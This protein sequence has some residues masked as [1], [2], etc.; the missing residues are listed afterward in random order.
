MAKNK[1]G[2][3]TKMTESVIEKLEQAF[4]LGCTDREAS[5]YANIHI[6][7]L[8]EYCRKNPEFAYRKE[9]LKQ[10][11][12]LKARQSVVKGMDQD[13]NHSLRFL[14]RKKKDEFSLRQEF[15]GADGKPLEIK[16][17]NYKDIDADTT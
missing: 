10:A 8:Y 6:D 16:I 4:A 15:S 17:V 12:V 2:R 11:P 13:Y 3:P 1:G 9:E 5:F 14:E 7:T